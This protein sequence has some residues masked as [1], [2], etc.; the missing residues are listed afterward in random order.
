MLLH[1][2]LN[3]GVSPVDTRAD[4]CLMQPFVKEHCAHRGRAGCHVLV[5][6]SVQMLCAFLWFLGAF[7]DDNCGSDWALGTQT[8]QQMTRGLAIAIS[9]SCGSGVW[10]TFHQVKVSSLLIILFDVKEANTPSL[11][12]L[13]QV[14]HHKMSRAS[15]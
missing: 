8:Q 9:S 12:M 13:F 14:K 3:L 2:Q 5:C 15:C 4:S 7:C 10:I 11:S 6:I 1:K